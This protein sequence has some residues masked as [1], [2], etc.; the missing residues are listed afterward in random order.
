M[1]LTKLFKSSA[2]QV[3][4]CSYLETCTQACSTR[5]GAGELASRLKR[6]MDAAPLSDPC[7]R[8]FRPQ[9]EA[10]QQAGE[11]AQ[12]MHDVEVRIPA[13]FKRA[14]A[15]AEATKNHGQS[16]IAAGEKA[17][18]VAAARLANFKSQF[19]AA[20][21][22][23]D[24]VQT[25]VSEVLG[26]A[27]QALDA[28]RAAE[29]IAAI[30][31]AADDL[32]AAQAACKARTAGLEALE[33][34]M[35]ILGDLMQKAGDG[36][37]QAMEQVERGGEFMRAADAR[38]L[39]VAADRATLTALLAHVRWRDLLEK[40]PG[41]SF[42]VGV[43]SVSFFFHEVE[44]VPLLWDGK[45]TGAFMV[46]PWPLQR[47]R[48]AVRE[49]DF[50]VFATDPTIGDAAGQPEAFAAAADTAVQATS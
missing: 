29:D 27:Q 3:A 41:S 24:G 19:D 6:E 34:R 37:K 33:L 1:Q 22:E 43:D 50:S 42:P 32:V 16:E 10:A 17:A 11:H 40:L 35:A 4:P 2:K 46:E 48:F 20:Q 26:S 49:P 47:I 45:R 31:R 44:N 9:I 12:V 38:Q 28:A 5:E 39:A 15:V 14:E 23:R 8:M 13:A 21:A 18:G 7:R 25:Q 30:A 36:K